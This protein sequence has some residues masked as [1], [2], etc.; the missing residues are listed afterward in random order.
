[1]SGQLYNPS[2]I[3]IIPGLYVGDRNSI[4][5]I[6]IITEIN[7]KAMV[8]LVDIESEDSE[9]FWLKGWINY[10]KLIECQDPLT[11][12]ILPR[13]DEICNFIKENHQNGNVFIHGIADSLFS[14]TVVIA[15][16]IR[17]NCQSLAWALDFVQNYIFF[18]LNENLRA[19][20][21]IWE[22]E[23]MSPIPPIP[24]RQPYRCHLC[25]SLEHTAR[26]L[27]CLERFRPI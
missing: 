14:T 10:H 26:S 19:Q 4:N 8:S 2:I 13:F 27:S 16:L 9:S 23:N 20:L 11:Q 22:Y 24:P 25:G 15:Y 3:Q 21:I 17:K 18:E 7:F 12:N 1:M 6:S 5:Y